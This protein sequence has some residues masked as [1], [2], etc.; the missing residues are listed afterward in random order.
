MQELIALISD[1]GLF[2][3]KFPHFKSRI[4]QQE[5][6]KS[7]LE[8]YTQEKIALIEAAT[9]TGK[10]IAYLLPALFWAAK[11][12]ERTVISTNTLALQEQLIKKDLPALI[13]TLGL[14]VKVALAKGM[15][16]YVCLRKLEDCQAE[17]NFLSES[18]NADIEKVSS[19]LEFAIEGTRSEV[20]GS[21]H[22]LTWEKLGA[23]SESCTHMRCPH[24][25]KCYFFKAREEA[26]EASLVVANHHL[27]FA[28]LKARLESNN[29]VETCILPAY[30]RLIIDEAHNIEEVAKEYFA[31]R[32]SRSSLLRLFNR[33]LSD[34]SGKIRAITQKVA[35]LTMHDRQDSRVAA[36]LSALELDLVVEKRD[37]CLRID[38]FFAE[39]FDFAREVSTEEKLRFRSFHQQHLQW[40][41]IQK[42]ATELLFHARRFVETLLARLKQIEENDLLQAKCEG[43]IADIRGVARKMETAFSTLNEFVFSSESEDEVKWIEGISA[44]IQLVRARIDISQLVKDS[45]FEKMN[46]V[47]LTSATLSTNGEFRFIKEVLGIVTS[48]E[49]IF[50]SPFDYE[51]KTLFCVPLDMLQPDDGAFLSQAAEVIYKAVVASEGHAF[52]LF[53]SYESL[54]ATAAILAPRLQK[55]GYPL[56]IQGE[57]S[58]SSLL[59]KFCA[60]QNPVLLGTDSFWEGVDVVG[61]IL[62]CV[63]IVK[64]PFLVP[65]DPFFQAKSEMMKKAGKSPFYDYSLPHA[66]M[67]FKQGFGRLIRS[68]TDR[69]CVIC[70]D[71]RIALKGYGKVILGTLPNSRR[72]FEPAENVHLALKEFFQSW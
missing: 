6:L 30:S 29:Y 47:V 15:H 55:L 51:N 54:R 44:N 2:S 65:S 33:L 63:I 12:G 50:P 37:V 10:S 53:T 4:S 16:N 28:D 34:K 59:V 48:H 69:G 71:P 70:L 62:R 72:V 64:L 40:A 3:Q 43:L 13:D 9:G 18:E 41:V 39:I 8:A 36:L 67:K 61:D 27:L 38:R 45:L 22:P 25:K 14:K 7:V 68:E 1:E 31:A 60:S 21:V 26:K 52:V 49:K 32:V 42:S 17:K 46:T 19:K 20:A 56:L 58:S 11:T 57:E 23:E 35:E 5:M 66:A 24:Y